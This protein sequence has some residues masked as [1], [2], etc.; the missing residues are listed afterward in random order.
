MKKVM[1][2]WENYRATVPEEDTVWVI[3]DL[4]GTLADVTHRV[5]LAEAKKWDEFNAACVRDT[6]R[7]AERRLATMVYL[8]APNHRIAICT[9]RSEAVRK[10]TEEWFVK[11]GIP[12][13]ELFMRPI[14]DHRPDIVL[15]KEMAFTVMTRGEGI[16]FVVEDRDKVVAMW[17]EL[18]ITCF[19]CQA[20]AY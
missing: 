9:G 19:Q 20:G 13:D 5:P 7:N 11:N 4:D 16:I 6:P 12:Y 17:R 2:D 1:D 15:K 14:D 18:G 10:E 3:F 8:H